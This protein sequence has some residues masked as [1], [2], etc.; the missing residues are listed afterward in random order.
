[1]C[2]YGIGCVAASPFVLI[3]YL[4]IFLFTDCIY[5]NV[6]GLAHLAR[7]E[8]QWACRPIFTRS[9]WDGGIEAANSDCSAVRPRKSRPSAPYAGG[10]HHAE[11]QRCEPASPSASSLLQRAPWGF[12]PSTCIIEQPHSVLHRTWPAGAVELFRCNYI[13]DSLDRLYFTT[14]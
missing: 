14:T 1:M 6:I 8:V 5:A 2:E 12:H 3:L 7:W 10:D 9:I 13:Y 11:Q 4:G